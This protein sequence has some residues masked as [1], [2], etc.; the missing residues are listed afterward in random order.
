[1]AIF[2]QILTFITSVHRPTTDQ[3][4]IGK[5]TGNSWKIQHHKVKYNRELRV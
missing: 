5:P 4:K 3:V 1:M 2:G